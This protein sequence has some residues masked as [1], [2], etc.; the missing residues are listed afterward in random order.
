M[1]YMALASAGQQARAAEAVRGRG[2]AVEMIETK[3]AALTRLKAMIPA[4]AAVMTGGSTTLKQIGFEAVLVSGSHPWNNLKTEILA[5]PD[6][7][8]RGTLRRQSTLAEYF[9]G[10]VHAIAET[11]EIVVAS[12]TGSQLPAYVFSSPNVIWVA[13]AQKI[14]PT[15]DAALRR[16]WDHCLPMEDQ[17]IKSEGNPAGSTVGKLLIFEREAAGLGRKVTLLLVSEVLGF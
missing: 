14:T 9:L 12:N 6:A 15:L 16:V 1:D 13:G 8:Q 2:V 11:G 17:R 7:K 3:E 4:G 10:S 5:E